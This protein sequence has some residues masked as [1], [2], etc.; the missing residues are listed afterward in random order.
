MK[1]AMKKVFLA[2]TLAALSIPV[3]AH[4]AVGSK[5]PAPK[6][7]VQQLKKHPQ[8]HFVHGVQNRKRTV[9]QAATLKRKEA[10]AAAEEHGMRENKRGRLPSANHVRLHHQQTRPSKAIDHKKHNAIVSTT[11]A[12]TTSGPRPQQPRTARLKT[13]QLTTRQASHLETK[14]VSLHHQI[15]SDRKQDN[16]LP[17][18]AESN[19]QPNKTTPEIHLKQHNARMF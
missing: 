5:S 14:E 12:Q 3:G 9:R 8:K 13:G 2:A 11:H 4:A 18:S 17:E 1:T 19:Q 6:P 7:T 16:N 10:G 15:R